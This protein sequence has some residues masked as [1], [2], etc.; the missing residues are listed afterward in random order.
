[1]WWSIGDEPII[2]VDESD[3]WLSLAID[4]VTPSQEDQWIAGRGGFGPARKLS[5]VGTRG[6]ALAMAR[7]KWRSCGVSGWSR[8][9]G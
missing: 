7:N 1:M 9:R 8:D 3:I 6:T 4:S 5:L 2:G